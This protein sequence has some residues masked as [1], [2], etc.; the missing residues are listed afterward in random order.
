MVARS[1]YNQK[2]VLNKINSLKMSSSTLLDNTVEVLKGNE[3]SGDTLKAAFDNALKTLNAV[4][5]QNKK[6][7]PENKEKIIE[8]KKI[9]DTYE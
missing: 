4:D 7:I 5:F 1:L 6:S 9:G 3:S 2:L 8:L